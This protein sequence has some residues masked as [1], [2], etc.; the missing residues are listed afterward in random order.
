MEDSIATFSKT[1]GV[2]CNLLQTSCDALKQS[3]DR[4]PIP[5]D[6]AS[7]TF[8][9]CLNRRVETATDDLSFLDSVSLGFVEFSKWVRVTME[10]VRALIQLLPLL[11][12]L[13][14]KISL[15]SAWKSS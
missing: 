13:Q 7:S 1:P 15:G 8:V 3:M 2:F 14:M 12:G 5:L 6:S 4:R 10:K 11:G 9:Q